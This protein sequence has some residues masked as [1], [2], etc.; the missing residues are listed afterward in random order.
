MQRNLLEARVNLSYGPTADMAPLL[1]D[2]LR[3]DSESPI[4]LYHL[5]ITGGT[6]LDF[7]QFNDSSPEYF[8]VQNTGSSGTIYVEWSSAPSAPFLSYVPAGGFIILP[9]PTLA[10]GIVTINAGPNVAEI[11]LWGYPQ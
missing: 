8:V 5:R 9:D 11:S 10:S 6:I 4:L 7:Q 1:V 2:N 3:I